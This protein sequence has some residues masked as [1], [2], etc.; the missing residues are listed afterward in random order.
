MR[1]PILSL[2]LLAA[3]GGKEADDTA[4]ADDTADT[5][6]DTQTGDG[7]SPTVIAVTS[8][9][10]EKIQSAGDVWSFTVSVDDPQ[11]VD[12]VDGGDVAVLNEQGGELASYALACGAGECV[13]QFR[14][15]YDGIG[16]TMQGEVT[17]RFVVRDEDGNTSAPFDHLTEGS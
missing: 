15:A 17:L 3:C 2:L 7:V 4:G 10:C 11:G 5:D 14:A 16:C 9:T 13:G 6:T 1:A 8:L 12:T